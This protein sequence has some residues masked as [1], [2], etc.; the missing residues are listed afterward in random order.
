[1]NKIVL[2]RLMKEQ[3]YPCVS[4]LMPT[5]RTAPDYHQN[6]TLLKK[7]IRE[8]EDRL[9]KE[10]SKKDTQTYIDKLKNLAEEVDV[11]RTKNG[12]ALFVNDNYFEKIDLPFPVKERVVIDKT[13]VTRDIIMSIN[14]SI[15]YYIIVL[16]LDKVRLVQ[17]VRDEAFEIEQKEFPMYSEL[18]D[19]NLNPNDLSREK[20]KVVKDFFRQVSKRLQDLTKADNQSFVVMG[21][22]KNLGFFHEVANIKDYTIADFEGSYVDKSAHDIGKKVWPMVKEVMSKRRNNIIK[23]L[24]E[25]V[26]NGKY[27]TDIHQIWRFA[28][29]GRIRTLIAEESYSQSCRMNEDNSLTLIDEP[30]KGMIYDAVDEIAEMAINKGGNVV[31]VDDGLLKEYNRIGAILRY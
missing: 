22:E 9:Q 21:V 26:D 28:N 12:L 1:M 19:Y 29:D 16:S 15:S 10:L 4:V 7:L 20:E 31:F 8:A 2:E 30:E 3:D 11:S 27:I 24:E 14:R 18:G 6:K 5:Y 13:F 23:E 17:C 25:A